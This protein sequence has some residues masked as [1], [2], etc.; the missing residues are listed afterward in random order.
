MAD[1]LL[2]TR[3]L[4]MRDLMA[5]GVATAEVVSLLEDA[6]SER[7]WW[8]EQWPAGVS[9]V[10]GLVAQDVQDALLERVGRWPL[11]RRCADDDVH[12]LYIHPELGGPD[13]VWV[14]ERS[15]TEVAPLGGLGQ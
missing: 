11:C 3:A 1:P 7:R 12:A 8:A 6:V 14:C 9:Y 15:G 2:S 10:D 5:T 4:V 13:P